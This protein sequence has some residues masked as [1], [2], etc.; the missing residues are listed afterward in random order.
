MPLAPLPLTRIPRDQM[1]PLSPDQYRIWFLHQLTPDLIHFNI[2]FAFR[3]RGPFD[4]AL[5]ARSLNA[6]VERHESLRT[7]FELRGQTPEQVIH[8]QRRIEIPTIDLTA[9]ARDERET[10]ARRLMEI[11]SQR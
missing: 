11:S 8:P 2:N 7:T 10:E 4:I 3:V 1:L 6:V 9:T 5:F